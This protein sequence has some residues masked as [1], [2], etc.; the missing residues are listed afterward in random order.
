MSGKHLCVDCKTWQDASYNYWGAVSPFG[1]GYQTATGLYTPD[2]DEVI[3]SVYYAQQNA[4]C[5]IN[6]P[7]GAGTGCELKFIDS[8]PNLPVA[9]GGGK[10]VVRKQKNIT[11]Q[12]D[13]LLRQQN[14]VHPGV[15]RDE[16]YDPGNPILSTAH[17]NGVTLDS[18]LV[19]AAS[20]M[21]VFDSLGNDAYANELFHEILTSGLD[22]NQSDIRWRMTWGRYHMKG[23]IES[24]FI[25]NELQ[26]AN[27][28]T[29]F[30][31]P[32]QYYVDVLNLMTDTLLTDSTYKEQFYLELDKGQ[33]LRTIGQSHMARQ[34]FVHLDDCQLD[35]PEQLALNNWLLEVDQ[36][37]SLGQQYLEQG[38]SPDQI[39]LAIDT[40]EYE[41]PLPYAS[42]NYYFGMWIDSPVSH[43]FM[44]CGS[45]LEFRSLVK[46]DSQMK[47]MLFP[48][49]SYG[50]IHIRYDSDLPADVCVYDTN[51]CLV[52]TQKVQFTGPNHEALLETQKLVP[53]VYQLHIRQDN[54]TQAKRFVKI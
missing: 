45:D 26:K 51:G 9:C 31:Q 24:M 1:T 50:N 37:I 49:P 53:G 36:E 44:T 52:W 23:C 35:V 32:V 13:P 5:N 30:E 3:I 22:R 19:F 4:L 41:L 20:Q 40:S 6:T 16:V 39:L 42:S 18:A 47:W 27:N 48:N 46:D 38:I 21:E 12:V 43:T 33:L 29:S 7:N 2:M 25:Q 54:Q 11:A 8:N 28:T 10:P 17:F 14:E 34:A 15:L